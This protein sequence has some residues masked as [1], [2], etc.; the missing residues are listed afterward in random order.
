MP[1]A[2]LHLSGGGLEQLYL[3]VR[4]ALCQLTAPDVPLL[5]DDTLAYFDDQ[6]ATRALELLRTL[7]H[8]RQVVVFSC[9]QREGAWAEAHQVPHQ[10]LDLCATP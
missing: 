10:H 5:L 1:H 8:Q 9:H 6:R 4:L 2:A 3:A 7:A